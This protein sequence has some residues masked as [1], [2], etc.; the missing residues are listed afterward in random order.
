MILRSYAKVLQEI[1]KP[2]AEKGKRISKNFG[3]AFCVPG[4]V[5]F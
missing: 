1:R 2:C 3:I 4:R 5:D